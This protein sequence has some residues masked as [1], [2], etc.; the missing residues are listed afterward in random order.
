M[1]PINPPESPPKVLMDYQYS[2][3]KLAGAP[4]A[5]MLACGPYST[6]DNLDFVPF[7]ALIEEARKTKPDVLIL[8]RYSS[9]SIS[10]A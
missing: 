10:C 4:M 7:D 8:V 1:P 3:S 6:E 5:V 2:D 9:A